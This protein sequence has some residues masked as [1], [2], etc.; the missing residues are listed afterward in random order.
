MVNK[1]ENFPPPERK[2]DIAVHKFVDQTGQRKPIDTGASFSMAVT[3]G[4]STWLV[5]ALKSAGKGEW[6][7]VV[8]RMQ[9]DQLLK[10]RQIIRNTRT[11]YEG[12][13][14]K[15]VRPLTFAGVFVAGGIV[16]YDSNVETGGV[17]ARY[18]GVGPQV[19]YRRD[20]VSVGLRLISVQTGEVLLAVSSE[21]TILS[22]KVGV[23]LF[24]FLDMGTKLLEVEAGLTENEST[25]YAVRKA[26]EHCVIQ[27]IEEGI[28]EELWKFK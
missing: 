23:S 25:S 26:I 21:K 19:E 10:E 3:Q 24:T 18:L 13:N 1:L 8:E 22:A 6:F 12:E 16:G 15:K 4:G 14:A 11:T 9:L 5:Q 17:G 27:V 20:M 7:T 2:V 28:K